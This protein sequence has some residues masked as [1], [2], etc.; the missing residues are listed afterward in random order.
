[1]FSFLARWLAM[2]DDALDWTEPEV[3]VPTGHDARR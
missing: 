3:E 2:F 1:M